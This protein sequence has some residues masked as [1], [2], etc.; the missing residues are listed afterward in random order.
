MEF[1]VLVYAG[2]PF[3]KA[4]YRDGQ[5]EPICYDILYSV[6]ASVQVKHWPNTQATAQRLT[7][8][9]SSTSGL[10]QKLIDYAGGCVQ[11]GFDYFKDQFWK[12]FLLIV[13]AFKAAR[14]FNPES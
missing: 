3:V 12:E 11:L 7:E 10:Q 2:E 5:L 14:L 8:E 4:C 1:C 6:K 13:K 9:F